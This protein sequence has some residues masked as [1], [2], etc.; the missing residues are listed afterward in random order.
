MMQPKRLFR[1]IALGV[2]VTLSG[3]AAAQT[4]RERVRQSGGKPVVTGV[5]N[6]IFPKSIDDLTAESDVV[7][8]AMVQKGKTSLTADEKYLYT[9]YGMSN[10]RV[11]AGALA[12]VSGALGTT[13]P[14]T[15]ICCGGEMILEGVLVRSVNHNLRELPNG[16]YLLFLKRSR[17]GTQPGSYQI[18]NGGVFAIESDKVRPMVS[19]STFPGIKDTDVDQ[20]V[21]RVQSAAK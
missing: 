7:V 14:F 19:G 1:T 4:L 20:L 18:Y 5:L 15:L 17:F 16:Q 10:I 21:S 8:I 6:D 12:V 13:S 2:V 3:S 11:V 9:E